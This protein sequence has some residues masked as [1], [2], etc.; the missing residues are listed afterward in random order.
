MSEGKSPYELELHES[1]YA[2]FKDQRHWNITRVPGGWIYKSVHADRAAVFIPEYPEPVEDLP[3]PP[4][5]E[6]DQALTR[7][8][9]HCLN[10]FLGG[11]D[12]KIE[13]NRLIREL[14]RRSKVL[15]EA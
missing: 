12:P 10:E 7:S 4:T 15:E 9:V 6:E 2:D 1:C 5:S 14:L 8:I 13:A 3:E 11:N